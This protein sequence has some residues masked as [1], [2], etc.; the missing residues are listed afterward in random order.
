MD[1]SYNNSFGSSTQ[2][3]VGVPIS[4][5]TGDIVL[6]SSSSKKPKKGL[7]VL[8]VV[9]VLAII[10]LVVA[11]FVLKPNGK[12]A[13]NPSS[14]GTEFNKFANYVLSG[15][16]NGEKISSGL[17]L[18]Y[19]YYL[20]GV[21]DSNEGWDIKNAVLNKTKS[22]YD[23]F[24][25]KYN[26]NRKQ[27]ND[28][29][30]ARDNIEN[31]EMYYK[32]VLADSIDDMGAMIDFMKKIYSRDR[33][34]LDVITEMYLSEGDELAKQEIANYYDF[35]DE[36]ENSYEMDFEGTLNVVVSAQLFLLQ[37]YN[38]VGCLVNGEMDDVCLSNNASTEQIDEISTARTDLNDALQNMESYYEMDKNLIDKIFWVN[39]LMY[40][41]DSLYGGENDG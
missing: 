21:L 40:D 1:P 34:T 4:S 18:S 35:S 20:V 39:T 33:I 6:N 5:G 10:G 13:I 17:N 3:G 37:T 27:D 11:Y 30:N 22:L 32:G 9:L 36:S 19:D 41:T 38:D 26:E 24:L 29:E 23:A 14:Y 12:S 25:L 31:D 2:G 8:I 16:E 28:I 15:E 7:I